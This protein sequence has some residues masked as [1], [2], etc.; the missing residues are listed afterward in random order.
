MLDAQERT[1]IELDCG[2]AL[3]VVRDLRARAIAGW[4]SC[5]PVQTTHPFAVGECPSASAH[6]SY[7]PGSEDD[8]TTPA[9]KW[10]RNLLLALDR[11]E[12]IMRGDTLGRSVR[13]S[14]A[15]DASE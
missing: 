4:S 2:Q 3:S 7:A 1:A 9:A 15:P 14:V 5:A 12:E 6:A 8:P 11:L 13:A 10:R